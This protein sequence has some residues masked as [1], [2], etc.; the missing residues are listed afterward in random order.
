MYHLK[1][2]FS[3][4]PRSTY[5]HRPIGISAFAGKVLPERR[6]L[7][8]NLAPV[9]VMSLLESLLRLPDVLF[10][11]PPAGHEVHHVTCLELQESRVSLHL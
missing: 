6:R 10:L 7:Q 11:A 9:P 8:L 2:N 4:S 1:S 5:L 3:P